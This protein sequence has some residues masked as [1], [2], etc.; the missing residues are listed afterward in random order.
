MKSPKLQRFMSQWAIKPL[1]VGTYIK[2]CRLWGFGFATLLCRHMQF[3]SMHKLRRKCFL[4][5]FCNSSNHSDRCSDVNE[6]D[7]AIVPYELIITC[8]GL[9][10]VS[11]TLITMKNNDDY[12]DDGNNSCNSV[13]KG[14]WICYAIIIYKLFKYCRNY[15]LYNS[16]NIL[17]FNIYFCIGRILSEMMLGL[18]EIGAMIARDG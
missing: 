6:K 1:Q 13:C 7:L 18:D 11:L 5:K 16:I 4:W 8:H 12:E 14:F 10:I 15:S 17:I 3:L 2:I 9:L